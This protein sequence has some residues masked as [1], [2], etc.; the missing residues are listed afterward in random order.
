[1]QHQDID[2]ILASIEAK[3]FTALS[4]GIGLGELK[5][6]AGA[7]PRPAPTPRAAPPLSLPVTPQA[8]APGPVF[9]APQ[10]PAEGI[11]SFSPA[12]VHRSIPRGKRARL[13][14]PRPATGLP[15]FPRR[16]LAWGVDFLFVAA[17]LA[18]GFTLA[19]LL[20]AVRTGETEHPLALAP[21][22]WLVDANPLV[23]L[24]GIYGAFLAYGL[25]FRLLSGRTVGQL[26]L[27]PGV[28]VKSR[29]EKPRK[30]AR[31]GAP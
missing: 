22:Q 11:A 1:M 4:N 9:M 13:D 30:T 26:L 3:G 6:R 12:G 14:A 23:V 24:A 2:R 31:G 5:P 18:V 10:G 20:S 25:L 29:P 19:T 8:P 17:T 28:A 7:K 21:V 16:L 27:A 15:S